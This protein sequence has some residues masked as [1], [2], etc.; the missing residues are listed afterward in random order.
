MTALDIQKENAVPDPDLDVILQQSQKRHTVYE[1]IDKPG[2]ENKKPTESHVEQLE[3]EVCLR[4]YFEYVER[5]AQ[6]NRRRQSQPMSSNS[7]SL[8]RHQG[9]PQ[10]NSQDWRNSQRYSNPVPGRKLLTYGNSTEGDSYNEIYTR[11]RRNSTTSRASTISASS[12]NNSISSVQSIRTVTSALPSPTVSSM[13]YQWEN[14]AHPPSGHAS[15]PTPQPIAEQSLGR[16]WKDIVN[17]TQT[18]SILEARAYIEG[19]LAGLDPQTIA[20]IR[21]AMGG[22]QLG[23]FF[24]VPTSPRFPNEVEA[25]SPQL[26]ALPMPAPRAAR[27]RS[28]GTKPAL[29]TAQS[30][31][32]LPTTPA[33]PP[34]R[35]LSEP[36]RAKAVKKHSLRRQA[37][38]KRLSNLRNDHARQL[39]TIV[40]RPSTS[41]SRG[42]ESVKSRKSIFSLKKEKPPPLPEK[43]PLAM[44]VDDRKTSISSFFDSDG[45]T[46]RGSTP[47]DNRIVELD[48]VSEEPGPLPDIK[49][50]R[51][52]PAKSSPLTSKPLPMTPGDFSAP[53]E[54]NQSSVR[55]KISRLFTSRKRDN[56]SIP[57]TM[58]TPTLATT[59]S[60]M[61]SRETL[62]HLSN[63][64]LECLRKGGMNGSKSTLL[65]AYQEGP[66]QPFQIWLN[67]LP[68]IEGRAPERV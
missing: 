68:Y 67:A 19:R 22:S 14:A 27:P 34:A 11:S 38:A 26:D 33:N 60:A 30:M 57:S 10:A 3:W 28:V 44:C 15:P 7:G 4:K 1:K 35:A 54:Y 48:E 21:K 52:T 66:D 45:S 50:A 18:M 16:A 32:I 42:G 29:T 31:P 43:H 53:E 17:A 63:A 39:S 40:E 51:R 59:K 64:S 56:I 6:R 12:R 5:M 61:R 24:G 47:E 8:V 37:S 46:L 55:S 9:Q 25:S 36:I 20:E 49:N 65:V 62:G 58:S 41:K 23:Q 2:Q 13:P